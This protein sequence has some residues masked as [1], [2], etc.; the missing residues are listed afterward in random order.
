MK[1]KEISFNELKKIL[2]EF[3]KFSYKFKI[4]LII[5][6]V[7]G[8]S[9]GFGYAYFSKVNYEAKLSFV[10]NESKSSSSNPLAAIASQFNFGSSSLNLSEDKILFLVGTKK[11]LGQSL[12]VLLKKNTTIA[13]QLYIN[14][15]IES[16]FKNDKE[17]KNF[18]GFK[19]LNI[20]NLNYQENKVIDL[21]LSILLKSNKLII[22]PVK[23]KNT[24]FVNLPPTGIIIINFINEDESISK[25]LVESIFK[26]LSSFY[27]ESVIKNLKANYNLVCSREDSIRKVMILNDYETAEAFDNTMNVYKFKGKVKQNRL[28]KENELLSMMYAEVIKNKEIAKFNLDQEKPI[29]QVIDAPTLPL[30]YLSKSKLFYSIIGIILFSFIWLVFIFINFL[31]SSTKKYEV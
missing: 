15:D 9:L 5:L 3:L 31:N 28:R 27:E 1:Q 14:W 6:I 25:L 17:I 30:I 23:K 12:L 19:N 26:N 20:D 8:A 18:K 29:L 16:K 22:E 13:D 2:F 21:L 11:I 7:S 24:S 4:F 10:L